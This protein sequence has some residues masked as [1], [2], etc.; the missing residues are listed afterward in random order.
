MII[1]FMKNDALD[2]LTSDIPNNTSLYNSNEKWL[3]QYFEEKGFGSYYFSSGIMVPDVELTVGD[4]KTDFENAV[5]I[6]EAFKGQLNPVQASDL[7]LWSFLAHNTYW[8]YMRKRWAID[9]AS[10]EDEDDSGKDK[11]VSRIGSR[12]FYKASKGK[13]F[14]RQGISRLYWSAFL[15]YDEDNKENP[16]EMTEYFLSKQDIFTVSTERSLARYKTL[17]LAALKVL[18][19]QGDLKRSLIRSYFLNL[20]QA[21]GIIVF[22]SLSKQDAYDL[23]KKTLDE[24]LVRESENMENSI[25][26]Q[27]SADA[28]NEVDSGINSLEETIKEK[29]AEKGSI[30]KRVVRG[31]K[32]IIKNVKSNTRIPVVAGKSKFQTKPDLI[33]LK[34]GD[35]FKIRKDSWMIES[36][37]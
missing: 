17:L 33:G 1:N 35:T 8:D 13:A 5:K 9:T 30:I 25:E 12:Y 27:T 31:S 3:D 34:C 6:F 15:T 4:S 22:D 14:V 18:K 11:I 26:T 28:T 10:E 19:E 29:E 36:I 24:L 20:N 7:R 16:Y 2:M 23:A 32:V 21:G 37:E